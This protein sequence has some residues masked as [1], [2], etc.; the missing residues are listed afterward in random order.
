[1]GMG[2]A[3]LFKD[4]PA[5]REVLGDASEPFDPAN[6]VSSLTEKIE[7]LCANPARCDELGHLALARAKE[8]F[9]WDVV[10]AKYRRM[11]DDLLPPELQ[12]CQ[13]SPSSRPR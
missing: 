12:S 6:P 1:M 11:F 7:L 13:P 10:M 8:T 2:K 9:S 4:S 3:I 5:T